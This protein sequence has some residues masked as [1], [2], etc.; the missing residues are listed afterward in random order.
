MLFRSVEF[1]VSKEGII[2]N[3]KA[4]SIPQK[5]APC[6]REAVSV[7]ANGPSWEPAIQNN[8]PVI[9]RQSQTINFVVQ[10]EEKKKGGK[11]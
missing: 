7:I 4:V 1:A 3:V 9:Y 11:N 6:A 2:S 5:C 8:V 10:E